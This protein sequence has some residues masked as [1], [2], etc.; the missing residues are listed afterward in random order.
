MGRA[1]WLFGGSSPSVRQSS[2]LPGSNLPPL[3]RAIEFIDGGGERARLDT[4]RRSQLGNRAGF[5]RRKH[6]RHELRQ[7]LWSR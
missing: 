7:S 2:R 5:N 6:R 3:H 1:Q 4:Q